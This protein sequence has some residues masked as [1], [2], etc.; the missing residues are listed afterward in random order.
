MKSYAILYTSTLAPDTPLA[1]VTSILASARRFNQA[2]GITGL[3]IFDGS[4]FAHLLEGARDTVFA[5]LEKIRLDPRHA[6]M[7]TLYYATVE[8]GRF[9]R[10]TTGTVS[11]RQPDVLEKLAGMEG[12]AA[13]QYLLDMIP[14]FD[15]DR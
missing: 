13:L 6:G 2:H 3:L 10:F 15:L 11:A 1:A 7:K 12:A 5:L 8:Q 14:A 9:N 4:R